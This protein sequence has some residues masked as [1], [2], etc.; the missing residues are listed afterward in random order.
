MRILINLINTFYSFYSHNWELFYFGIFTVLCFIRNI[1][2]PSR[3][4]V[5]LTLGFMILTFEFEYTKHLIPHVRE[6][7][8][9]LILVDPATRSFNMSDLFFSK[10]LPVFMQASGWFMIFFSIFFVKKDA[11]KE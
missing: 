3:Y 5:L 6:N 11:S 10:L 4:Y 9:E 2:K 8:T 7:V 1:F